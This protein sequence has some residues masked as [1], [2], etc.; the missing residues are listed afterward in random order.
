MSYLAKAVSSVFASAFFLCFALGILVSSNAV[1]AD[2]DPE[3]PIR[4]RFG[5]S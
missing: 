4:R 2:L 5:M 1:L 3:P